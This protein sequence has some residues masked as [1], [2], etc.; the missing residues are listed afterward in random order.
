VIAFELFEM[1]RGRDR[2]HQR[3]GS[4]GV[5]KLLAVLSE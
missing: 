5:P 1:L 2:E 4:Q 3:E